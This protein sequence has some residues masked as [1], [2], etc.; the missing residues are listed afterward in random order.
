V[1]RVAPLPEASIKAGT[2]PLSP[3]LPPPSS[4]L[5][6][7]PLSNRWPPT[8]L[9]ARKHSWPP[10][11]LSSML[12]VLL[13]FLLF[14]PFFFLLSTGWEQ[15]PTHEQSSETLFTLKLDYAGGHCPLLFPLTYRFCF[16]PK[17]V[18][19]SPW[20]CWMDT[21][22]LALTSSPL[23]SFSSPPPPPP[24]L[25]GFPTFISGGYTGTVD[26]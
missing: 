26:P 12:F 7:K 14:F 3:L 8:T 10:L 9:V 20:G 18:R 16:Q 6:Q 15:E 5:P 24:S 1:R 2:S 4:L 25:F 17:F 23:S 11:P 21:C 22:F 19:P 13:P